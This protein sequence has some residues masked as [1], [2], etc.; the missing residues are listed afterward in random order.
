MSTRTQTIIAVCV[1]LFVALVMTV[2]LLFEDKLPHMTQPEGTTGGYLYT[3]NVECVDENGKV[4]GVEKLR[5][6]GTLWTLEPPEI[7]GY[8]TDCKGIT[9]EDVTNWRYPASHYVREAHGSI[10]V[11]Y[12]PIG[13]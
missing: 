5:G 7:E 11:V 1:G 3:F 9:R 10:Q 8:T 4:L 2:S 6:N 13:S 12:S